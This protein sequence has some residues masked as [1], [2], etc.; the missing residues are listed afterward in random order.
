MSWLEIALSV[1]ILATFVLQLLRCFQATSAE[2]GLKNQIGWLYQE[3]QD[4]K[5]KQNEN[6]LGLVEL[7]RKQIQDAIN[8]SA[9]FRQCYEDLLS[10]IMGIDAYCQNYIKAIGDAEVRIKDRIGHVLS[11]MDFYHQAQKEQ[12]IPL[13]AKLT[14]LIEQQGEVTPITPAI[15]GEA[16]V[17]ALAGAV[18][19]AY[20]PEPEKA[21]PVPVTPEVSAQP[22]QANEAVDSPFSTGEE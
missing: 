13:I 10:N 19:K 2:W 11:D 20:H 16:I 22:A 3:I 18:R 12:S 5:D 1:A 7:F 9:F 15:I 8:D 21:P 6:H 17:L 14:H 4:L